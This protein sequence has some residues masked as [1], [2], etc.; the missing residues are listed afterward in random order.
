MLDDSAMLA[1]G[2][3]TLSRQRL[4]EGEGRWLKLVSGV[5]MLGLAGLLLFQPDWLQWTF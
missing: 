1:I 2:V 3:V 5:V 4:Q